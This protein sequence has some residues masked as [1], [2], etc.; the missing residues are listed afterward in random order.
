MKRILLINRT[1]R[2]PFLIHCSLWKPKFDPYSQLSDLEQDLVLQAIL[3]WMKSIFE[4]VIKCGACRSKSLF[5]SRL[6]WLASGSKLG[7][8]PLIIPKGYWFTWF[9][10]ELYF[11]KLQWKNPEL[12]GFRSYRRW[13][14]LDIDE[15]QRHSLTAAFKST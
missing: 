3:E 5:W 15:T 9:F 2:N 7:F 8:G 1:G 6:W 10:F 4:H 11:R 12:M 13:C 14:T